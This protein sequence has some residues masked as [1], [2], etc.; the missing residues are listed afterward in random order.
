MGRRPRSYAEYKALKY[1]PELDGIRALSALIV[2]SYHMHDPVWGWL[3]GYL[4]VQVFF[5]LSGYLI[6]TLALREEAERGRLC[7]SAFYV[8][9]AGRILPLYYLTVGIY[10]LVIF[11]L[12]HSPYKQERLASEL[13]AYLLYF[14]ELPFFLGTDPPVFGQSWSLGIEEKFYLF[15]PLLAFVLWRRRGVRYAGTIG[16]AAILASIP[17]F[18]P[19][20]V[21]SC[22]YFYAQILLGCLLALCLNDRRGFR[23][24]Q[25]LGTRWGAY[26]SLVAFLALHFLIPHLPRMPVPYV[27]QS[28]YA[29]A[30]CAFLASV[31]LGDGPVQRLLRWGPLVFVGK[32]SYGIYLIHI[33]CLYAA[34]ML[35]PPNTGQIAVSVTAFVLAC[36]LSIAVAYVLARLVE[37]PCIALGRQWSEQLMARGFGQEELTDL[38][39]ADAERDPQKMVVS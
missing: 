12:G 1:V 20:R 7:L 15:W 11:G 13:P 5:V 8:R 28:A 37:R 39:G 33:L 17:L 9:R 19:L 22:F 27:D 34:E 6:T 23:G 14:Q 35:A 31:L 32:L 25:V 38:G 3:V 30:T 4:G 29:V 21:A 2:I 36:G 24:L 18:A 10:C 16:A 26:A